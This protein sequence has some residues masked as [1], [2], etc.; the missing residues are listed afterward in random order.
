M[1]AHRLPTIVLLALLA[2][3]AIVACSAGA[4]AP[5]AAPAAGGSG[6]SSDKGDANPPAQPA[7]SA[8]PGGAT[9]DQQLIVYT[10]TLSLEVSDL[11]QAVA[12]ADQLIAG[13]GGHVASSQLTNKD[14]ASSSSVTYRIPAERWADALSGLRPIGTR[15]VNENT[16][17]EDV[18]GQV[19][20]LDARITNLKASES[21]LQAIMARAS[22]IPDVLTVQ[23]KLTSVQGDIESMTAQR[24]S[25]ANRAALAT[26]TVDFNVPVPE[27]TVATGGWDL[28]HEVDNAVAALVRLGQGV[29]TIAVWLLIV[30]LPVLVPLLILFLIGRWLRRRWLAA[31]PQPVIPG[32]PHGTPSL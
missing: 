27:T 25:L 22:T 30:V 12:Q 5:T 7:S 11:N 4:S 2:A 24:D 29:T 1:K 31:H 18:T 8:A 17:S 21:A 19:I 28:G 3:I 6:I 20:D 10:G 14:N 26:L 15:V 9:P 13:L 32:P 23:D 16:Q